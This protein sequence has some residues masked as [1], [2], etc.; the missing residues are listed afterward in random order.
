LRTVQ[1]EKA[2]LD[3]KADTLAR[4]KATIESSLKARSEARLLSLSLSLSLS[5]LYFCMFLKNAS[6][7]I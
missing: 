7:C 4:E 6:Q 5:A 1:E 2:K 3:I